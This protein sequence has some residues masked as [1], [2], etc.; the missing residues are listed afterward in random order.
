MGGKEDV[1][2]GEAPQKVAYSRVAGG[3]GSRQFAEGAACLGQEF[4]R[5]GLNAAAEKPLK[6][7]AF[8]GPGSFQAA[9]DVAADLGLR[10]GPLALRQHP[11][12][13]LQKAP[14]QGGGPQVEGKK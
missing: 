1:I 13:A 4:S 2:D 7:R 5:Q 6:A 3:G 11:P 14:G 8:P 12:R 9:D 10:I